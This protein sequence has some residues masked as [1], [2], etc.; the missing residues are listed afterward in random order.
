MDEVTKS[1][2]SVDDGIQFT[3][4]NRVNNPSIIKV[5]GVGGGGGNA[6]NHMFNEGIH[7]VTYLVCNTDNKALADSPVPNKLQL[8]KEGLGAGNRPALARQ[9]ALESIEDVKNMLNDGTKMAFI[10]AGMGG[11]T[12]TG[13]APIIAQCAKEKGILTVGIVTIPFLFEGNKKIDQALEGV[14][15][16]KKHVDALLVINNERLREIYPELTV[17]NA[18]ARADDTLSIAARSIAEIIT[19]RGKINLDFRDVKTVLENGG[20]A[21]MST[22]YG[23]G[24]KRISKA[25]EEAIKSPLLNNNDIFN[26]KKVLLYINFSDAEESQQFTME[27]MNEV[28]KFMRQFSKDVETKWGMATD[29]TLGTRI[30]VTLLASGFGLQNVPG[31]QAIIEQNTQQQEEDDRE[32]QEHK[33]VLRGVYYPEADRTTPR[34]RR[35]YIFIF[36]PNE[37]DDEDIISRV[38]NTPTFRRTKKELD[39][40]QSGEE[41]IVSMEENAT[42]SEPKEEEKPFAGFSLD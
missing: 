3:N 32:A 4:L 2:L 30:K 22:G 38:E 25:I 19:M 39:R 36:S 41:D 27:E 17:I 6:V 20:V 42:F 11:G 21:L 7:D 40:I 23:E 24:E 13:A 1:T 14:E 5:I 8:G 29:P 26:S 16:I 31:M 9:A 33:E 35:P 18:F 12:G 10:T 15:E 28:H 34:R 37:L